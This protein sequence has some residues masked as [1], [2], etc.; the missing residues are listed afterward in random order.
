MQLL[1]LQLEASCFRVAMPAEVRCVFLV[2]FDLKFQISDVKF[3]V[4]LFDL[5]GKHHKF[6]G[7]FRG[8]FRQIFRKLRF[9]FRIFFSE[10]LFSRRAVLT[11]LALELVYLQLELF[12]LQLKLFLAYSGKVDPISTLTDCKQRSSTA[13]KEAPTS[14]TSGALY[15]RCARTV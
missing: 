3:G 15:R 10:T 5:P 13:S 4:R 14:P 1:C 11:L 8:R 7:E 12:C 9:K 2:K 6:R